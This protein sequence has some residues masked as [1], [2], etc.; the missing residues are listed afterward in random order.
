MAYAAANLYDTGAGYPGNRVYIYKSDS[1][2]YAVVSA[3]GYFNN[4][5][6]DL[7]MTVDDKII[8]I[9]DEGG[10]EL[11][12]VSLSSGAVTTGLA[13]QNTVPVPA[14]STL[15]LTKALHD[16][17]TIAWDTATGSV[18]TLPAA[19]GTGAKFRLAATVLATSN[20]HRLLCAGTDEFVGAIG[21]VDTDTSDATIQFAALVGDDFDD[22]TLN[23]TTSGIAGPG[24]WVEVE[25]IVAGSWAVKGVVRATGVV[26]T[27]FVST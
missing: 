24:D 9:G 13:D 18:V 11:T 16:G 14:G 19:T 27:P 3:A 26:I 21:I 7:N 15:T 2:A 17:K 4:S 22:I 8:V 20:S 6:D 25:D 10:Y 1:D 5:D 12:V 23:R